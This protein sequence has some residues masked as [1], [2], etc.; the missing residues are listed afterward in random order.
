MRTDSVHWL[1]ES[2]EDWR[3]GEGRGD[4][5]REE[6]EK[7]RE[8]EEKLFHC[9]TYSTKRERKGPLESFLRCDLKVLTLPTLNFISKYVKMCF[10]II[11]RRCSHLTR[12]FFFP[13][14]E[15]EFRKPHFVRERNMGVGTH[16]SIYYLGPDSTELS[17]LRHLI[18]VLILV[19][20]KW[21]W[22]TENINV[23]NL[24]CLNYLKLIYLTYNY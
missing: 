7:E 5:R 13:G 3:K 21:S 23:Q 8:R 4:E 10:S 18:M 22:K 12:P 1:S 19:P 20:R 16:I 9:Y 15:N 24:F 14:T 2:G 11:W 17:L 6:R